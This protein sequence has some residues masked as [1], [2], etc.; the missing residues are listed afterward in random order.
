MKVL[1][2]MNLSPAWVQVLRLSDIEA[3]HWIELGPVDA[4]DSRI[5]EFARECGYVILTHDLDF[6]TLLAH[7]KAGGPSV[8]QIRAQDVTPAKLGQVMVSTLRQFETHLMAGA[9]VTV[10]PERAKVRLLPL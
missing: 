10:F 1:V 7:S 6:G 5:M 2:D 3:V 4:E 9:L 8:I